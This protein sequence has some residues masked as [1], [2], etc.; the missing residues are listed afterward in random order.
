MWFRHIY[1]HLRHPLVLFGATATVLLGTLTWLAW[2]TLQQDQALVDQRIQERLDSTADLVAAALQ[3]KF[4]DV[5]EQL[6]DLADSPDSNLAEALSLD[7]NS[8]DNEALIA[9]VE[10]GK[11]EAYPRVSLRYYP[12]LPARPIQIS[13]KRLALTKA[14]SIMRR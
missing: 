2:H 13:P 1:R 5:E 8:I 6:A 9:I 10:S 3:D 4:S 12:V 11:L 7:K 14:E